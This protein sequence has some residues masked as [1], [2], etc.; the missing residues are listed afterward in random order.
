MIPKR[1][2]K[3]L[4]NDSKE[5]MLKKGRKTPPSLGRYTIL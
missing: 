5:K 3:A 4:I 2:R 1:E